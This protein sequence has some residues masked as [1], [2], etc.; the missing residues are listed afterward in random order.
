MPSPNINTTDTL[1]VGRQKI[2]AHF[3]DAAQHSGSGT[4]TGGSTPGVVYAS[5]HNPT[6]DGVADDTAELQ[7]A[8]DAAGEGTCVIMP[9]SVAYRITAS[10]VPPAGC[11]VLMH[12]K[13]VI[14]QETAHAPAFDILDKPGVTI[15]GGELRWDGPRVFN[16][17]PSGPRG[18]NAR[19][20]WCGIYTNSDNTTIRNVRIYGFYSGITIYGWGGV[21]IETNGV[22]N[23]RVHGVTIDTC[24][25]GILAG[26]FDG[27]FIDELHGKFVQMPTGTTVPPWSH[28]LYCTQSGGA[29]SRNLQIG[30]SS[31]WDSTDSYPY[32]I[33]SVYGG[34]IGSLYARNCIGVLGQLIDVRNLAIGSVVSEAD[35]GA[36]PGAIYMEGEGCRNVKIGEAIIDLVGAQRG[37]RI[38]G[39][40][41]E[42][43][44]LDIRGNFAGASSTALV[45][46]HGTRNKI[47][48]FRGRNK[49]AGSMHG[50]QVF[51]TNNEIGVDYLS[52]VS[53]AVLLEGTAVGARV[54]Y[55][56]SKI[57]ASDTS[58][59][60]RVI[61]GS[62]TPRAYPESH[63]RDYAPSGGVV[64]IVATAQ[65]VAR[66]TATTTS[67]FTIN[68]PTH[69]TEGYQLT[70]QVLNNSGGALGAITWNAA[71]AFD[72]SAPTSPGA[73]AHKSIT[74]QY[75]GTNWREMH[76]SG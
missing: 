8:L 1:N 57:T 36:Q 58:S 14:R 55:D 37:A 39:V 73:G 67:G 76:R 21:A 5:S 9:P 18:V 19:E 74:F 70:V 40:D 15:E 68:T 35:V 43:G 62:T 7:A 72:G 42:V 38:D 16:F 23:V 11:H 75:D 61:G 51:G 13:T 50:A 30:H 60:I 54:R 41:V 53:Q 33:K 20:L 52:G 24:A 12:P 28:M 6:G 22:K 48:S 66:I 56:P 64:T 29:T 2:N 63:R 45:R 31:S 49:G 26:G 47:H 3:N 27:L 4:G 46:M 25:S 65:T 10:L 44:M 32:Q 17:N 71:F 59:A 69:A 34:T